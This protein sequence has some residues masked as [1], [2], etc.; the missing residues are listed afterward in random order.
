MNFFFLL[1]V[2]EVFDAS[3]YAFFGKD[4]AVEEVELGGL[5][6]DD[7][8]PESNEEEFLLDRV[9]VNFHCLYGY[10]I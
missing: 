3:Q 8:L 5:E 10:S 9:E 2:G 1:T 7:D 6:D 4:A